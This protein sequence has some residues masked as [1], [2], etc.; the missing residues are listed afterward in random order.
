MH[1][2]TKEFLKG[3]KKDL[4]YVLAG[5]DFTTAF[6]SK[7]IYITM[8]GQKTVIMGYSRAFNKF[9]EGLNSLSIQES[10]SNIVYRE[11]ISK[12]IPR[13]H[14]KA[15]NLAPA[16]TMFEGWVNH[17]IHVVTA[18]A[19]ESTSLLHKATMTMLQANIIDAFIQ[20]LE[21]AGYDIDKYDWTDIGATSLA[22]MPTVELF[23]FHLAAD[24][25]SKTE[26]DLFSAAIKEQAS[27]F[28]IIAT[29]FLFRNKNRTD[30]YPE[31]PGFLDHEEFD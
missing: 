5:V 22:A 21:D 6:T 2:K 4:G 11:G 10:Y 7:K 18:Y 9:K 28:M 19:Q 12:Y 13:K 3:A 23:K 26:I 30:N 31:N 15:L 16:N 20:K 14:F 24:K 8:V 17:Y 25:F 29:K 1:E 27:K